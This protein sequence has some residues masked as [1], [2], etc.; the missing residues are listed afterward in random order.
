[1]FVINHSREA[2]DGIVSPSDGVVSLSDSIAEGSVESISKL[3]QYREEIDVS[4][5]YRVR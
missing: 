3:T 2:N 4:H 1:M 5:R